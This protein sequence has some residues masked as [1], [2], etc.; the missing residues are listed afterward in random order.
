M[1]C[2][3]LQ[4]NKGWSKVLWKFSADSEEV[5]QFQAPQYQY[6]KGIHLQFLAWV[7]IYLEYLQIEKAFW[8]ETEFSERVSLGTL[9]WL[10]GEFLG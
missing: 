9:K 5:R 2:I 6:L 8:N 1:I 4:S 7:I 3:L 10:C